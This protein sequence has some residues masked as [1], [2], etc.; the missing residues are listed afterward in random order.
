MPPELNSRRPWRLALVWGAVLGVLFFGSYNT[1]NQF[2]ATRADVGIYVLSWEKHIPFWPWTIVP[3]WSIDFLYG[4]ALFLCRSRTELNT[5]GKRLLCAQAICIAGF[6]FWPLH[7]SFVR[8]ESTG[9]FGQLFDALAGFDLPYNQAPSLHICLLLVLWQFYAKL[10]DSPLRRSVVH[11]WF[12][13][14]GISVLTTYQHHFIDLLTG[15]WAGAACLFLVS[16]QGASWNWRR[17]TEIKRR[18]LALFY[19]VGALLSTGLGLLFFPLTWAWLIF[20]LAGALACVALLYLA[21][22]AAHFGKRNGQLPWHNSLLLA[23]YLLGAR[24][25]VWLWTRHLPVGVEITH[26]IFLGRQ[27]DAATLQQHGIRQVIDL[28][29]ELARPNHAT[30]GVDLPMLDLLPPEVLALQEAARTIEQARINGPV[31]VCCA[32]GFSRSALAVLAWLVLYRQHTLQDA[33]AVLRQARP[34]IVLS[35]AALQQL[36]RLE[37]EAST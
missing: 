37:T 20:W 3:Y 30:P 15:L 28:A 13:L 8:P 19:T 26:G 17:A 10:I 5:L 27:P 12:A 29:A 33:L 32:L 2:T 11:G 18:K 6:L 24:I 22:E 21:G 16:N 7:F 14:I 4:L 34:Q 31:W 35:P 25:N 9:L 36:A 1:V 23:P